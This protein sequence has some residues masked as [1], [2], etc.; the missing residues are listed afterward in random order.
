MDA[1]SRTIT[2][3]VA[4]A[5]VLGGCGGGGDGGSALSKKDYI[6]QADRICRESNDRIL[7]IP[8]PQSATQVVDYVDKAVPQI[9]DALARLAKLEA[10]DDIKP[11][12]TELVSNLRRQR[13]VIKQVG[14]AAKKRDVKELTRV[15]TAGTKLAQETETKAKAAGF[16]TCGVQQASR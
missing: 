5:A 4:A 11:A 14:A 15:T 13:D 12:A 10:A 3:A 9:D 1:R 16:K 2:L 7:K 6:A 8:A